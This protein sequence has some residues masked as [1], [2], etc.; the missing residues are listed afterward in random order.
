MIEEI[1]HRGIFQY[2]TPKKDISQQK[3]PITI[4]AAAEMQ[5]NNETENSFLL[6]K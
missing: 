5:K 2:I 6:Y 4:I 3:E 1:V